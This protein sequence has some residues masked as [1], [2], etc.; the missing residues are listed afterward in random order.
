MS[1]ERATGSV[2]RIGLVTYTTKPRGGV[3]H[4]LELAEALHA[5]GCPV[6]VFA[7]GDPA[8][9]FFRPTAVPHTIFPA[10]PPDG[11]LED[12]VWSSVSALQQEL[13]RTASRGFGV[14]HAQDC[15]AAR[16][17]VALREAGAP[18]LVVRT[19]HHIDD[20]TTE[21]LVECQRRSILDPDR[22]LVVSQYWQRCLQDEFGVHADVVTNGVNPQR[23]RRPLGLDP[24]AFRARVGATGRTL[25][26]TVG[27]IEPRKGTRELVEAMAMLRGRL[28][29][30]PLLAIVGGHSFQDYRPYAASVLERA[31]ALGLD[32]GNDIVILGTVPDAELAG[33]YHSADAFVFPSVK[34]GWGLALLEAMASGL[35]AVATDIP[36]FREFLS[37]GNAVLVP[38]A[39][40]AAL[41]RAMLAVAT[42]PDLRQRLTQAGPKVAARYTWDACAR[43]H[44]AI[45]DRLV[46]AR[47]SPQHDS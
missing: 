24:A 33:W 29:P 2:P 23:S 6:H 43:Q 1:D 44:L 20:F 16:A 13:G 11:T 9:G 39:D 10:P 41:S 45:Y 15:I 21:A 26:L 28:V 19:V 5:I 34:E 27:G 25:F 46:A 12:R 47:G 18:V 40:A 7:L 14:L 3:I 36:V 22:V 31:R 8:T 30:A 17:A 4:C 32:A 38:P 42:D 35:P 37:P